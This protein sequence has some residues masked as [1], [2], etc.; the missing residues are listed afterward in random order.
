[1]YFF[2]GLHFLGPDVLRLL[3]FW[4]DRAAATLEVSEEEAVTKLEAVLPKKPKK[5]PALKEKAPSEEEDSQ[6]EKEL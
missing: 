3:G 2:F 1:L 4:Q 5:A 6:Q